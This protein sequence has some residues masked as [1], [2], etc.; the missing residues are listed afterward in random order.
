MATLHKDL[1]SKLSIESY[2]FV[3]LLELEDSIANC[4]NVLKCDV[5]NFKCSMK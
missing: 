2:I 5:M 3:H 1:E 4:N